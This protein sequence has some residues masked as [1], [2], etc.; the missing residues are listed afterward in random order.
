MLQV[1]RGD[2]DGGWL[3]MM[4]VVVGGDISARVMDAK[5]ACST[6]PPLSEQRIGDEDRFIAIDIRRGRLTR[7]KK[8]HAFH[9]Y[10]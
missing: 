10:S 7:T 9:S 1:D 6:F 4:V 5:E 3:V 2:S 8:N